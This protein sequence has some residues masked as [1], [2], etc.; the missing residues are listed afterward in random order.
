MNLTKFVYSDYKCHECHYTGDIEILIPYFTEE[1]KELV[2][3]IG[4]KVQEGYPGIVEHFDGFFCPNC[5]N[6]G[7]IKIKGVRIVLEDGTFTRCIFD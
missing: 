2:F 4:D 6:K 7:K 3:K 1:G 5:F